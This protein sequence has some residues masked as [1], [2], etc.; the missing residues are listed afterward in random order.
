MRRLAI[1]LFLLLSAFQGKA[2]R[3]LRV[4]DQS[5]YV[6]V[7][8]LSTEDMERYMKK[9]DVSALDSSYCHTVVDSFPVD[10]SY[11]KTLQPG[12]YLFAYAEGIRIVQQLVRFSALDIRTINDGKRFE[13]TIHDKATGALIR[14]AQVEAGSARIPFDAVS[15]TYH[16]A[17][18]K[19]HR[20]VVVRAAG[21]TSWFSVD[22]AGNEFQPGYHPK[23]G[24]YIAFNKPKYLPGDTVKL[25]IYA[26]R[27]GK[28]YR[29]SAVLDIQREWSYNEPHDKVKVIH[30]RI[31]PTKA[32][33]FTY[34][35]VLG[36]S[37]MIDHHYEVKLIK[38]DK[39]HSWNQKTIESG[40]FLLEDYQLDEMHCSIR[41]GQEEFGPGDSIVLRLEAR[42]ANDLRI[43]DARVQLRINVSAVEQCSGS[44]AEI[45]YETYT[46]ERTLDPDG[47]T[48]IAIDPK[49]F[50]GVDA[51]YEAHALFANSNNEVS[52]DSCMINVQQQM[53]TI[54][55]KLSGDTIT[56]TYF[57]NGKAIARAGKMWIVE[58]GDT[59][60]PKTIS[61]PYTFIR[62]PLTPAYL[63]V[64]G[65]TQ[66][67]LSLS[68]ESYVSLDTK[69]TKDSVLI[70]LVN[71]HHLPVIYELRRG[72][73]KLEEGTGTAFSYK[74]ADV[75]K[76]LYTF[77]Y[78]YHAGSGSKTYSKTIRPATQTLNV[79]VEQPAQVFPGQKATVQVKVTDFDG[80]PVEG[81]DVTASSVNAQFT[82]DSEP[83]L[84]NFN[85]FPKLRHKALH[86]YTFESIETS[87]S[88]NPDQWWKKKFHLDT[89]H[90]FALRA[91][92][93]AVYKRYFNLRPGDA[94]QFSPYIASH[95]YLFGLSFIYVDD[96]PVYINPGE[97]GRYHADS[98]T[99]YSFPA[100]PGK[101][102][103]R[104]RT[105]KA[106]YTIPD[107][108][109]REGQ[110]LEF[111]FDP[112]NVPAGVIM[113]K[114]KKR[115]DKKERAIVQQQ[116]LFIS[117]GYNNYVYQDTNNVFNV[118]YNEY[119]TLLPGQPAHYAVRGS[120]DYST[121]TFTLQPGI[122]N[123]FKTDS[124]LFRPVHI[125]KLRKPLNPYYRNTTGAL[126]LRKRDIPSI[127]GYSSSQ[128]PLPMNPTRTEKGNGT[129]LIMLESDE[130]GL[131]SYLLQSLDPKTG[132]PDNRVTRSYPAVNNYNDYTSNYNNDK[133][134]AIY[135]LPA[136]RYR[137]WVYTRTGY[138]QLLDSVSVKGGFINCCKV[139]P[140]KFATPSALEQPVYSSLYAIKYTTGG[141]TLGGKVT[142]RFG[143]DV[144]PY[145]TVAMGKGTYR[146][147]EVT[148]AADG[149][150][151]F[152]QLQTG[153]YNLFISSARNSSGTTIMH[154][155]VGENNSPNITV[156]LGDTAVTDHFNAP[157]GGKNVVV[158]SSV[159]VSQPLP[160]VSFSVR[161][162]D[163]FTGSPLY[164]P[165]R[166]YNR[167]DLRN[168]ENDA[169]FFW[170]DNRVYFGNS[171][172]H[173]SFPG[174]Y[175]ARRV[176]RRV[177]YLFGVK[178]KKRKFR[179]V[180]CPSFGYADDITVNGNRA[181]L[182]GIHEETTSWS[183]D[184]DKLSNG[185]NYAY[186]DNLDLNVDNSLSEVLFT[187]PGA[188]RSRE[189]FL[190]GNAK[191]DSTKATGIPQLSDA[192]NAK[193]LR[194]RFTDYAYWQPVLTTDASGTAKFEAVFPDNLTGW[195]SYAAAMSKRSSGM[196]VAFT[197][198]FKPLSAALA[199]PRFL[200]EGDTSFII[201]KALN[202]T[203]DSLQVKTQFTVE[204]KQLPEKQAYV[205]NAL[206]QSQRIEAQTS[207]D[208]VTVEF[209]LTAKDN[210]GDG[211]K[212]SI[213]VMRKG[214]EEA[215]G[216]FWLLEGDTTFTVSVNP[217]AEKI[218]VSAFDNELDV[219][220]GRIKQIKTYEYECN[221][222]LASKLKALLMEK[223]ICATLKRPFRGDNQVNRIVRK[224]EKTQMPE[225]CWGW[226]EGT[227][228]NTFMTITVAD[229][230]AEAEDNGYTTNYAL[231]KAYAYLNLHLFMF[232]PDDRAYAMYLL[233][234]KGRSTSFYDKD[235]EALEKE[236]GL[237]SYGRYLTVRIRQMRQ[238]ESKS[239]VKTLLQSK[240]E[241]V[242]GACYWGEHNTQ[243][244]DNSVQLTLLA[245]HIL[246]SDSG[247]RE[248]L[249]G[250]RS[251]FL[252]PNNTNAYRNTY[253]SAA[254]LETILPAYLRDYNGNL[255]EPKLTLSGAF[256]AAPE[257][258]PLVKNY[259]PASG[260]VTVKKTGASPLY[261]SIYERRW[262]KNP[263][264][265]ND[266]FS[267]KT[268][269]VADGK[270][271]D[272]LR[273]GQP[274]LLRVDVDVKKKG[275]YVMIEVPIPAGCSYDGKAP[276]GPSV[277]THRESFKD[278]TSIFCESL[279]AGTYTFYI[280]LQPRY[281]GTYTLNPAKTELMY[282]PVFYGRNAMK[283]TVIG[284]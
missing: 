139:D 67:R 193:R 237:T 165:N 1:I 47:P 9:K 177:G 235:V 228:P 108:E 179:T 161:P 262:N 85:R 63:F 18:I 114:C 153:F 263:Q 239:L 213:P 54:I 22:K 245:Y 156:T 74:A 138:S 276:A 222:Q 51:R 64:C 240:Q 70:T 26:Q 260:Q 204:G 125:K 33:V 214:V 112:F 250:I 251:Y 144:P 218:E 55:T 195:R 123:L 99:P 151:L 135:N 34:Q 203:N 248:E 207:G 270:T 59:I 136:G 148:A 255:Q 278:K 6:Y 233:E 244:Y 21:E 93:K 80:R 261:L 8:R 115:M 159:R 265:K 133:R 111:S 37:L 208:S 273:A 7:F 269:F 96:V 188:I 234:K 175:G 224:L 82:E 17:K 36:D 44:K 89:I 256:D 10:S 185:R 77:S 184:E 264:E 97:V 215:I 279:P 94:P 192:Q 88:K 231:S 105:R 39:R 171:R 19:K 147:K 90:S 284:K 61:Y 143:M 267:M 130:Y 117:G 3:I 60:A 236:E 14:D 205:K 252:E 53:R 78:R 106:E 131:E 71:P 58:Q 65:K 120:R 241:T 25:K 91:P 187:V 271:I 194:D 227:A 181:N 180:S 29:K 226:W 199:L 198:S 200:V 109:V 38:K 116:L 183:G 190:G 155:Y 223:K 229:A 137:I 86:R 52:K 142:R 238:M 225:G 98:N 249:K 72:K 172:Y 170:N 92:E 257:K 169:D 221:E 84:T 128:L 68:D 121:G 164:Y 266:L 219:L 230:L 247:H 76:E 243:W 140:E 189:E 141:N 95:G 158:Q 43:P 30:Q 45:P 83:T 220:L 132:Q 75:T 35:L 168:K 206:I 48:R 118:N 242:L 254:I 57:E 275:N 2:Q 12:Y 62:Q 5:Y 272:T 186:A 283:K 28:P 126:L 202:Y 104:I 176:V 31:T 167:F 146:E 66:Q 197:K 160:F 232:G 129:L 201:G 110:K 217:G 69:R 191:A 162:D 103:V 174:V 211:E 101:H 11:N 178:P 157:A 281:T 152:N 40:S 182:F 154:I 196:N 20:Y 119:V 4:N 124:L 50:A 42:D 246:E 73:E 282:F 13:L 216:Q 277:E 258:M 209:S 41:P 15:G 23:K 145:T 149:S 173:R 134:Q 100:T 49:L 102:T 79:E 253:E 27:K 210:Y 150:F 274:V 166:S 87:F 163:Y 32:G 259:K 113:R 56:A 24:S 107:V 268:S 122:F 46:L 127:T 16:C 81:A 280:S 212:R